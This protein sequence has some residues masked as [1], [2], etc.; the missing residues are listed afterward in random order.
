MLATRCAHRAPRPP[1]GARQ[2]GRGGARSPV[3]AA[4]LSTARRV[5]APDHP[6]LPLGYGPLAKH[7]AAQGFV[8][9][10]PKHLD[11]RMVGFAQDDAR[12]PRLWR[13]REND[14]VQVLDALPVLLATTPGFAGRGDV[15]RMAGAGHPWGAQSASMPLGARHPD[16]DD[17]SVVGIRDDRVKPGV[18]LTAPGTGGTNPSPFAAQRFPFMHPDFADRQLR[19][20]APRLPRTPCGAGEAIGEPPDLRAVRLHPRLQSRAAGS[21]GEFRVSDLGADTSQT[22]NASRPAPEMRR[23]VPAH[24]RPGRGARNQAPYV[25][26]QRAPPGRKTLT[27]GEMVPRAGIEPATLRFSVACSTN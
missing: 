12:R 27:E 9:I 4:H 3:P 26:S 15:Q 6:V 16:P 17:G 2:P 24:A 10:Q 1:D 23:D 7:W 25:R 19:Q 21:C 18:L 8:V 22:I 11:S 20:G 5:V 14:L 13:D